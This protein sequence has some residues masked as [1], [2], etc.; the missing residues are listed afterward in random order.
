MECLSIVAYLQPASRPQIAQVR[1]VDSDSPLRTL[2][3][4]ELI[5]D[6]GRAQGSGAMLYATTPRFEAMFG[7]A[8][9]GSLPPLE[10]FALSDD[11]K[12]DLRRR[13][14]LL[15]VPE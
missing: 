9:L 10:A 2:L 15:T 6:V 14:G 13:L 7:L 12:D 5:T 4:R 11:D 1:G 3:D 8:D